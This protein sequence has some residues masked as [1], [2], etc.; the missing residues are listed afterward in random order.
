MLEGQY[1]NSV[2]NNSTKQVSD[3]SQLDKQLE[4][5]L[6]YVPDGGYLSLEEIDHMLGKGNTNG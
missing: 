4:N 6:N 3:D 5:V 1:N 2:S